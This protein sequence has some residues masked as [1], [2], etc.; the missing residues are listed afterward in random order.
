M[1]IPRCHLPAPRLAP[2]ARSR[3]RGAREF[4][5]SVRL[6]TLGS[7]SRRQAVNLET[8]GTSVTTGSQPTA[9]DLSETMAMLPMKLED[10]SVPQVPEKEEFTRKGFAKLEE[11]GLLRGCF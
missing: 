2:R 4:S 3:L 10:V 11:R 7:E 8:M 1:W 9:N 5:T 6:Q